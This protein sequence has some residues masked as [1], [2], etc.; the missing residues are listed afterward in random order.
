MSHSRRTRTVVKNRYQRTGPRA[1]T[2]AAHR[3]KPGAG[4]RRSI[5]SALRYIQA[6]PL[7]QDER[8]EDRAFFDRGRDGVS[9]AEAR[10]HMAAQVTV[11]VAYHSMVLSPGA[12]AERMSREEMQEWTRRVMAD[13]EQ[14]RGRELVWYAVIHRHNDHPHVHVIV[15]ASTTRPSGWQ[16]G[17]RFTK[18]DFAHMRESGDRHFD[19]IRRDGALLRDVEQYLSAATR[20]LATLLG[21][22]LTSTSGGGGPTDRDQIERSR[23]DRDRERER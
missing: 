19:Q 23:H 1:N 9:R 12:G 8:P 16:E 7:G 6:R 21:R 13:L 11:N 5:S 2:P 22:T 15:G 4:G 17:V 10:E 20:E 3:G 18:A 14:H